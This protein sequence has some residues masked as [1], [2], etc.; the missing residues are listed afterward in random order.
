L[1]VQGQK[2][3]V[4]LEPVSFAAFYQWYVMLNR[5]AGV[6]IDSVQLTPLGKDDSALKIDVTLF[7]GKAA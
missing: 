5:T 4:T 6:Q 7:W 3:T 2:A 1:A